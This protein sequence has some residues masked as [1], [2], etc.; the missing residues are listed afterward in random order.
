MTQLHRK[1]RVTPFCDAAAPFWRDLKMMRFIFCLVLVFGLSS[2]ALAKRIEVQGHRGARAVRPENTLAAFDYALKIGVDVIELD[3]VVSKDNIVVVSHDPYVNWSI[4]FFRHGKKGSGKLAFRSM[5]LAQ[6]KKLDCGSRKNPK[7]PKQKPVRKQSIPTLDE[8]FEMVKN[9][10]H[11]AAKTVRFNIETKILPAFQSL[12]PKPERFASL[13]IKTIRRHKMTERCV[14]QSF[15]PR[16]LIEIKKQAP[17]LKT[18]ALFEGMQL[19]LPGLVDKLQVNIISPHFGWITKADVQKMREK[20]VKVI[21]WTANSPNI[22]DALIE[23]GVDGIITDDPQ[24]LIS[25]LK[26]KGLR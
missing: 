9:S 12:F 10:K 16:T 13:M 8:V 25:H 3:T 24:A 23:I 15:D 19:D 21:P 26:T 5:T 14:V 1:S 4:C 17:T 7:Y 20:N 6:I 2:E 18:A 11:P 22:W